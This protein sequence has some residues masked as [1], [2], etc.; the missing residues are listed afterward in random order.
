MGKGGAFGKKLREEKQAPAKPGQQEY[1]GLEGYALQAAA[2]AASSKA[3]P[4]PGENNDGRTGHQQPTKPRVN[5]LDAQK[6]AN[7]LGT[8]SAACVGSLLAMKAA[9]KS[10]LALGGA[11]L[12]SG[13]L[14]M[15]VKKQFLAWQLRGA[16]EE[17]LVMN[18]AFQCIGVINESRFLEL[19]QRKSVTLHG[20]KT[21]VT[22]AQFVTSDQGSVVTHAIFYQCDEAANLYDVDRF[23]F[24]H[25]AQRETFQVAFAVPIKMFYRVSAQLPHKEKSSF[26]LV[27]SPGRCGSTLLGKLIGLHPNIITISEPMDCTSLHLLASAAHASGWRYTEGGALVAAAAA[28]TVVAGVCWS[29]AEL[30]WLDSASALAAGGATWLLGLMV[31]DRLARREAPRLVQASFRFWLKDVG[32]SA[33]ACVKLTANMSSVFLANNAWL[34]RAAGLDKMQMVILYRDLVPTLKSYRSTFGDFQRKQGAMH[35]RQIWAA[36]LAMGSRWR[37]AY[38]GLYSVALE[39]VLWLQAWS[40]RSPQAGAYDSPSLRRKL[41]A[42]VDSAHAALLPR[43]LS[44]VL[45]GLT[46]PKDA[47]IGLLWR[48]RASTLG[49]VAAC[50]ARMC[51]QVGGGTFPDWCWCEGDTGGH[52]DGGRRVQR[53]SDS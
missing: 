29:S 16:E 53:A 35:G 24:F 1:V 19:C 34:P 20:F 2:A 5:L 17:V 46:G 44:C 48:V 18:R 37:R 42:L 11:T 28:G 7:A 14:G 40:L 4:S 9:N 22:G 25:Q 10:F 3:L 43:V 49:A 33:R 21:Q 13:A 38:M 12:A 15:W 51:S 8:L 31:S 36:A 47:N 6:N 32:C 50:H 30:S 23:P 52:R 41:D 26:L 45:R 39:P 27:P